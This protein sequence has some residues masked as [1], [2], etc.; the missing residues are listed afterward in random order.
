MAVADYVAIAVIFLFPGLLWT[1]AS[2]YWRTMRTI[3]VLAM[4]FALSCIAL[5]L[6]LAGTAWIGLVVPV[7]MLTFFSAG[8]G[9]LAGALLT[10]QILKRK[11]MPIEIFKVSQEDVAASIVFVL[12]LGLVYSYFFRYPVFDKIFLPDTLFHTSATLQIANSGGRAL[13][14]IFEYPLALHFMLSLVLRCLQGEPIVIVRSTLAAIESLTVIMVYI[15]ASRVLQSRLYGFF[16]TL[17]YAVIV[18]VGLIHLI[19]VGT[20]SNM[21]A[22]LYTLC[23]IYFFATAM[24]N[25]DLRSQITL[26]IVGIALAFSH[27]SSFIFISFIWV[28]LPVVCIFFRKLWK[29][30]VVS[31]LS[32]SLGLF[33]L[34]LCVP[35]LI[36][37][38]SFVLSGPSTV[39]LPRD[40]I[41]GLLYS[42]VPFLG[43]TYA[44]AGLPS[45]SVLLASLVLL[46]KKSGQSVWYAFIPSWF[47]YTFVLSLQGENIWRFALYA[48]FIGVFIVGYFISTPMISIYRWASELSS[49]PVVNKMN[50]R[51]IVAVM[52]LT[53]ITMGPTFQFINDV[54]RGSTSQRQLAIYDSM[55]WAD[56]NTPRDS[57]FLSIGLLEY[58][59]MPVVAN[60]TFQ[61]DYEVSPEEIYSLSVQ[62][63]VDYVAVSTRDERLEAFKSNELFKLKFENEYVLIF[64]IERVAD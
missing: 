53:L 37:R 16:S 30:Y 20:Y 15:T 57:S 26:V 49:H 34:L 50:S 13:L 43:L 48:M 19:D 28:F 61:G 42:R 41:F 18:P 38:I 24:K 29:A 56:K 35:N 2:T 5:P 11:G 55:K 1:V 22:N 31:S 58:T 12:H 33:S 36:Y 8:C 45:F 23:A 63:H 44:F 39:L 9:V 46:F 32:L 47:T 40:P 3:E 52:I 25:A 54:M 64:H 10:I 27:F 62:N 4:S 17:T 59:Y 21:L 51:G 7:W 6:V 14:R 60:R